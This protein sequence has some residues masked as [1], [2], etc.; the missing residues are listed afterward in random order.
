MN[1]TVIFR[2]G[3]KATLTPTGWQSED[4]KLTESLNRQFP[5]PEFDDYPPFAYIPN[6]QL[7]VAEHVAKMSGGELEPF[8]PPTYETKGIQY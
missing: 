5:F 1:Y 8:D 7:W 2:S 3:T 4:E 6:K